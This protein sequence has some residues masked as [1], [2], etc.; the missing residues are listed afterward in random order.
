MA[1]CLTHSINSLRV[2]QAWLHLTLPAIPPEIMIRLELERVEGRKKMNLMLLPSVPHIKREKEVYPR[3]GILD[4]VFFHIM[5][6]P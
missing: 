3:E 5:C 2:G 4:T 6:F 1:F